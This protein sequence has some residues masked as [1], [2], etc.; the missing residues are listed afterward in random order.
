MMSICKITN[1]KII[2]K[3]RILGEIIANK[4]KYA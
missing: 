2:N 1:T 4:D 3:K